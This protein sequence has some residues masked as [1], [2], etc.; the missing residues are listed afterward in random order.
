MIRNTVL[1]RYSFSFPSLAWGPEYSYVLGT[2]KVEMSQILI[3]DNLPHNPSL[4]LSWVAKCKEPQEL[5]CNADLIINKADK[6][7]EL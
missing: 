5:K 2:M 3:T 4:F 1:R 6:D 7:L